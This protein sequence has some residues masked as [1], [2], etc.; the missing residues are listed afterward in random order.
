MD[1]RIV[2]GGLL[3]LGLLLANGVGAQPE[4]DK[5]TEHGQ[6]AK[7]ARACTEC[8]R[9]CDSCFHRCEHKLSEG[10]KE[11]RKCMQLCVD[12]GEMCSTAGHLTARHS[13]LAN[14]IC[15]ACAKACEIC[16][17]ACEKISGDRHTEHCAKAC[18]SCAQAC[19]EMIAHTGKETT[20]R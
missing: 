2:I 15:E 6:H 10:S 18:R 11:Y 19:R 4:G 3:S 20:A 16:A 8:M 13:L 12:C 9:A 7:C 1:R 5:G 17:V 14:A